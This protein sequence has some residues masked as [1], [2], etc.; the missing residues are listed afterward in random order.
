[1]N[2][3]RRRPN[4]ATTHYSTPS[5][6]DHTALEEQLTL[7]YGASLPQQA[8]LLRKGGRSGRVRG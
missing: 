3:D 5:Q 4:L 6:I 1:M 8:K 2:Q 7:H